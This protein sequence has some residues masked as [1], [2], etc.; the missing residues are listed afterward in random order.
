VRKYA[1]F[2]AGLAA[3][4]A[5]VSAAAAPVPRQGPISG[6]IVAKKQGETAVLLPV[7]QQRPAEVRQDLKA[8]DVLRTNAAGT[9]AIVFA[10]R[11]QIR[12]GRNS[13]LVVKQV[14][15]GAP[16]SVSLQRGS[17]WARSPR[18]ASQLSVETPSATAAI[19]GTEYSIV[20]SEEQTTLTVV[21]GVVDFFNPQ[22]R[23]EVREGQSA[24][25]RLGQAPTRLFT[26]N[27]DSREQMH[28]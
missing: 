1:A 7:P 23:L 21:E 26:V 25:A 9:L 22:G 8:G 19:R 4:L 14:R 27:P 16:S 24:A 15:Q 11:T 2:G 18:G 28:Y 12:V 20:A 13:T 17:L 5:H 6:R 3:I 10:D